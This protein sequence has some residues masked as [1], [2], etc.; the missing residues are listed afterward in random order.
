LRFACAP[1]VGERIDD[2]GGSLAALKYQSGA[3]RQSGE[4]GHYSVVR[5]VQGDSDRS[6]R[7]NVPAD[8]IRRR[9]VHAPQEFRVR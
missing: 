4:A 3:N 6:S 9:C 2:H 7:Y 8:K 5:R 1:R